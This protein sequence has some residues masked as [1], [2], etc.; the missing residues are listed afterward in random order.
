MPPMQF[1]GHVKNIF[2]SIPT[3]GPCQRKKRQRK[4][5]N[6]STVVSGLE[7]VS[8]RQEKGLEQQETGGKVENILTIALLKSVRISETCPRYLRRHAVTQTSVN[9]YQLTLKWQTPK[10][11]NNNNNNNN[12]VVFAVPADRR[13]KQKESDKRD[14]YLETCEGIKKKNPGEDYTNHDWC[15][16]Y[17]N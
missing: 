15:I 14:K 13:I 7:T 16:L 9:A 12:Y 3:L 2:Q 6:I 1:M 10:K 4:Y 8:K 17:S 11:S 5:R